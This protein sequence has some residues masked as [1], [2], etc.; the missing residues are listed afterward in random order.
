MPAIRPKSARA[1]SCSVSRGRRYRTIAYRCN[2]TSLY[3]RVG[4]AAG[5][6]FDAGLFRVGSMATPR[7]NH[8]AILLPTGKVLVIG[9]DDGAYATPTAEAL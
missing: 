3:R 6:W 7:A 9:G 2:R 4:T 1:M 8:A 5:A